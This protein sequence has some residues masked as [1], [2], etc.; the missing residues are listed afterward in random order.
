MDSDITGNSILQFQQGIQGGQ[1]HA[2]S[3]SY[4]TP[5]NCINYLNSYL[6]ARIKA[7]AL[8]GKHIYGADV[9]FKVFRNKFVEDCINGLPVRGVNKTKRNM[10]IVYFETANVYLVHEHKN[11]TQ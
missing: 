10:L 2:F 8:I 11:R 6:P 7:S 3:H 1:S 4:E 5:N 9:I